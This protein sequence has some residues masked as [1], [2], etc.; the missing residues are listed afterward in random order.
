M[1]RDPVGGHT[2]NLV[3]AEAPAESSG[4]DSGPERRICRRT[5]PSVLIAPPDVAID[6]LFPP[7]TKEKVQAI[8]QW[9]HY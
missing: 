8:N 2:T 1:G 5:R 6:H 4:R 7:Y 9:F 3:P